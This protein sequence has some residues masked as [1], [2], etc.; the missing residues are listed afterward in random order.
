MV[1]PDLQAAYQAV[2]NAR[3]ALRRGQ[4]ETASQWAQ[5]AV[6]LSPGLED[7]W[8]V[9]AAV[10]EP[11]TAQRCLQQAL[12]INP[13]SQRAQQG[14]AWVRKRLEES[15]PPPP[16]PVTRLPHKA[17]PPPQVPSCKPVIPKHL[18]LPAGLVL[19]CLALTVLAA[20]AASPALALLHA[21]LNTPTMMSHQSWAQV[22][23][24]KPTYTPSPTPTFTPTP[25]DTP[26]P[27][28]TDTPTPT[29]TATNTPWPTN[30]PVPYK[31]PVPAPT[32]AAPPQ[33]A[34]SVPD[35]EHWLE[36]NLSQ[37]RLY[38]Y[39][40]DTLV[41]SFVVST[42]T[43]QTPTV[44]GKYRIYIKQRYDNM[45]GPGYYLPDVPYTMYFYKGYAIHGTYW[46]NNFG[47]PM[48]HGCVNLSIPDAEWVYNFS[49]IGTLV[50]IHY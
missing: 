17:S 15:A 16:S 39:A 50:Y 46:H 25:T 26:T 10:S 35:G 43:W 49:S 2:Q 20:F 3:E 9:L 4:M 1:T 48:S 12:K 40:G 42:G 29:E 30:T 14:L 13:S 33:P 37:Q 36:V 31:S 7:A 44:T 5:R 27:T 6:T 45:A 24:E 18:W 38:A 23:V 47:T 22:D 34:A 8:L 28:P 21:G 41:R 19:I 32:Y 11:R